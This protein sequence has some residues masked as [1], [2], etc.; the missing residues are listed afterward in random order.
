MPSLP[1]E[2][3]S[4]LRDGLWPRA[5]AVTRTTIADMRSTAAEYR[6]AIE[7]GRSNVRAAE[8][9]ILKME[10]TTSGRSAPTR[11]LIS[12]KQAPRTTA[13]RCAVAED[14]THAGVL[15]ECT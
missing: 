5:V 9:L 2:R 10:R 7:R 11:S 3:L 8:I 6:R 4:T 15:P 14:V 13:S 12:I 1:T